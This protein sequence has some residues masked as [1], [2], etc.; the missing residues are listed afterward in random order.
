MHL[1]CSVSQAMA[2]AIHPFR[3]VVIHGK[4]PR[5]G[6]TNARTRLCPCC[7][8][9]STDTFETDVWT[10]PSFSA[11]F[12]RGWTCTSDRA[13]SCAQVDRVATSNRCCTWPER[14]KNAAWRP[15]C[16]A[17]RSGPGWRMAQACPFGHWQAAAAFYEEEMDA[18]RKEKRKRRG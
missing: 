1:N 15:G 8:Q 16:C 5:V 4:L 13:C 7:V 14:S 2:G 17:T 6:S 10:S 9:V 11:A 3:T 18:W 12:V